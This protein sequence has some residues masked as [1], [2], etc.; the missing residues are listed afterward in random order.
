MTDVGPI[1]V[2]GSGLVSAPLVCWLA[3]EG[4]QVILASR[5]LSKA[6]EV[7]GLAAADARGNIHVMALDIESETGS[8]DL[9]HIVV[10]SPT[11]KKPSAIISLLPYIHHVA[12]ATV[13][14]EHKIHFF[15]T[16]YISPAMKEL[17]EKFKAAGIVSVNEFGVDPGL[18][19]ASAQQV[20]DECH[21]KGEKILEFRS[22]CG[23]LPAKHDVNP[24]GYQLSWSPRGVLLASRNPARQLVF[25]K[26]VEAGRGE[27]FSQEHVTHERV[28]GVE[29]ALDVYYNR[30]AVPYKQIYGIPEAL[31]VV[32]AT[33]RYKDRWCP[34]LRVMLQLG[35]IDDTPAE[36]STMLGKPYI[37]A[38]FGED[39]T[40]ESVAAK[41][42][43][44]VDSDI[45]MQMEWLGLLSSELVVPNDIKPVTKIDACTARFNA[46]LQYEVGA[47]DAII[48]QH[49]FEI[50]TAPGDRKTMTCSL[51]DYG[52]QEEKEGK[53]VGHSSMARTVSL[54]VA[55]AVVAVLKKEANLAPGTYGA[56]ERQ[57]YG[58][59]LQRMEALNPPIKFLH[60][61]L[62][63]LLHLRAETKVGEA[64]TILVPE[65][66][67]QLVKK[68]W[69][70]HVEKSLSQSPRC[71]PDS[72]YVAAG[73][74]LVE[75]GSWMKAPLSAII[76]GL[77]ELP[78]S[79]E[80][81]LHRHLFFAHCYKGQTGA[82]ELLARFK[83]N[84]LLW[85]LEF[86][87]N[88][89][90]V[91]AAAFGVESGMAGAG[92]SLL[93]FAGALG[94]PT[95]WTSFDAMISDVKN[96]LKNNF[97]KVMVIGAKGRCGSGAVATLRAAGIPEAN[98]TLWDME[99]TQ[100]GGPFDAILDHDVLINAVYI[101]K[102]SPPKP[103]LTKD[104]L[105]KN[106]RLVVVNDV[107]CDYA[108][109]A[110]PLPIYSRAT[111]LSEPTLR[112][113]EAQ[114]ECPAVDVIAIDHLPT[115]LPVLSSVNFS[116]ALASYL[117]VLDKPLE[118]R[119]WRDL[120]S[121]FQEHVALNFT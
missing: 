52:L 115:L 38:L 79:K 76:L 58:P 46:L 69:R 87:L 39:A 15:T 95:G 25:G 8:K 102:D 112:V 22:V 83:D 11:Q 9:D 56:W 61:Q 106:K 96:A 1:L 103:F 77:K 93:H 17:D 120:T 26:I 14:I 117:E 91:R 4:F 18:D 94:S 35:L 73:A 80:P 64:R 78:E 99:E 41:A 20:I 82:K 107:S 84:G 81:L 75:S 28:P 3:E 30:D 65:V 36:P 71:F 53:T 121:L 92:I 88:E 89:K 70:I 5:T 66:A 31:T 19:H 48:M 113:F 42:S 10:N 12:A 45:I 116:K 55:L 62:P 118:H 32:R 21:A 60:Q 74:E 54:P 24:L 44:P 109:P 114:D 34:L 43:L 37:I 59:V 68:G 7:A 111:T 105:A 90:G 2:L 101:P 50:E 100:V 40:V 6:E 72:D 119:A 108:S 33:Y 104:M 16:S 47:K 23:G 97:P 49:T 57:L 51:L 27:I 86:L 110:N 13:A 63:P 29:P 85:D 67:A 98:L